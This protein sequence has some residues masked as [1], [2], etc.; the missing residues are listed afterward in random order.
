MPLPSY[1][2]HWDTG[3]VTWIPF[4]CI[5]VRLLVAFCSLSFMY[6]SL[7]NQLLLHGIT[8]RLLSA[9][10]SQ[11]FMYISLVNQLCAPYWS[12]AFPF[13]SLSKAC[14]GA[15]TLYLCIFHWLT[16]SVHHIHCTHS[17]HI[18]IKGLYGDTDSVKCYF[19]CITA[20]VFNIYFI[21]PYHFV[22][23]IPLVSTSYSSCSCLS[24]PYQRPA[25]GR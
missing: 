20:R 14:M 17:F 7:I 19:Q 21:F 9:F 22:M 8:V 1:P 2:C 5:A 11:S 12:C 15:Q 4:H 10:Y 6:I 13:I 23:T 25:L 16:T 24:Y 18:L 3:S